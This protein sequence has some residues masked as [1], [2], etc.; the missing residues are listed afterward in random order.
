MA[1]DGRVLALN[2]GSSSVKLALVDPVSGDRSV[3]GLAERVGTGDVVLRLGRGGGH[4]AVDA[5]ADVT[6]L[7][8]VAAMVAALTDEE[9]AWVTAVGHR[10]VHGGSRFTGSVRVDDDVLIGLHDVEPLAPLHIPGNVAGMIAARAALPGVPNVAVFDTAF[11]R[12]LPPHAYHY[13]VPQAWFAEHGVRRYG[14]HG[15]SHRYVTSRA[16]MML[17]R[18]LEQL[19]LVSVHLGNGCSACAVRAGESVDTTMG[20]TPLEGLV[21]GTRS[22]DVDAGVLGYVGRRLGLDLDGVVAE[23]TNSSG[24]LGLSGLSNDMRT[25][26]DAAAAGSSDAALAVDVFCYRT[27]KAV[28]A[29]ATALDRVDAVVLTGGIG[30]HATSVRSGIMAHLAVLGVAE[31]AV[32]NAAHGAATSGRIS[33][34]GS[35]TVLV[36]PTDEEL[37]IARETTAVV[38]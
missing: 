7:G 30:E 28:C 10:V 18:P 35:T 31:D 25:L 37:V 12:T 24:L 21:M 9:R 29:M 34:A 36:V 14:F 8:V 3:E 32:A 13:A 27:A 26:V 20:L 33:A 6:H 15:I 1:S 17:G 11:H 22:G 23:L 16:A 5:P 38:G 2:C 19:H 4:I